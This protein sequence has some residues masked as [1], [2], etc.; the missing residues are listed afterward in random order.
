MSDTNLH[1]LLLDAKREY[2]TRLTDVIAPFIQH[3]M[4]STYKQAR[5]SVGNRKAIV[6]FQECLRQVPGWNSAIIRKYTEAIETKYD[7]F[8][9][10]VAAVFVS[11]VKVLSSIRLSTQR[12]T[13]K[14]KVPTNDS[15]VHRVYVLAAKA[16][17][18]SPTAIVCDAAHKHA[19]IVPAIETAVRDLMPMSDVLE[20]YLSSAVSDNMVNP[21]LSPA[22]S[23]DDEPP[24]PEVSV[25]DS[26]SDEEKVIPYERPPS[27]ASEFHAPPASEFQVPPA[28]QF[29]VPPASQFQA[30]PASQFQQPPTASEFHAPA[31]AAVFQQRPLEPR[32]LTAFPD[33]EDGD[34][35]F[36]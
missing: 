17:Y 20:A 2:L 21:V 14:L 26:D 11:Y 12:P 27:P 4:D 29:Q 3:F 30:P 6:A 31:P 24:Q 18:D 9:R 33:A 8:S 22:H 35:H 23:D 1:P 15:F 10:L 32:A 5:A 28:S 16:F 7:F 25:T 19:L 34:N 13:I 36:R